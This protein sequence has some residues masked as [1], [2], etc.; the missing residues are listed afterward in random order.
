MQNEVG[1]IKKV[2][3][4]TPFAIT[5]LIAIRVKVLLS[6]LLKKRR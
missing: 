6:T 1:R 5:Y 2:S 3:F 4:E